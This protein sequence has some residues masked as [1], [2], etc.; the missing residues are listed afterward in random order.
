[1]LNS[2]LER[3]K[4]RIN[5]LKYWS[6]EIIHSVTQRHMNMWQKEK[7]WEGLTYPIS[8][9]RMREGSMRRNND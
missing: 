3:A 7:E 4:E 9:L 2:W 8:V 1:M 6:V 5:E